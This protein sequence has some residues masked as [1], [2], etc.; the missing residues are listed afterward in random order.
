[1]TSYTLYRAPESVMY[2]PFRG[3]TGTD[4]TRDAAPSV[5]GG[6]VGTQGTQSMSEEAAKRAWLGTLDH[7]VTERAR[8]G[9]QRSH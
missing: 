1:M 9:N 5:D 2:P 6:A 4:A 3:R 7:E 8:A